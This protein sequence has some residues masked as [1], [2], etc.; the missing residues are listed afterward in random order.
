MKVKNKRKL[1]DRSKR[2][3]DWNSLATS[4]DIGVRRN[5]S[6]KPIVSSSDVKKKIAEALRRS[7]VDAGRF[8]VNVHDGTVEL[9]GGV[10]SWAERLE[11]ERVSR[12]EPGVTKV[13]NYLRIIR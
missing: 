1:N 3:P 6:I 2:Q 5:E 4:T 13:D 10:R 8:V 9:F 12:A 7:S 11:A